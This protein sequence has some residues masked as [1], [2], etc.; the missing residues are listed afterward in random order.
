MTET[1]NAGFSQISTGDGID[2][3]AWKCAHTSVYSSVHFYLPTV[4]DAVVEQAKSELL[5]YYQATATCGCVPVIA[6]P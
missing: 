5:A 6:Q 2:V 3:L 4:P 1:P